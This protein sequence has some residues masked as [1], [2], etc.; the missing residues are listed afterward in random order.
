MMIVLWLVL[1]VLFVCFLLIVFRGAPYVPTHKR[2]VEALFGLY[3]FKPGEVLVDLGSGDGRVLV[4]AAKRG[5]RAVGYELN[6]FLVF[7]SRWRL[8]REENVS[9]KLQDF[10][11]A[12]LPDDTAVV[13]VFLA[14]PFMKKLDRKLTAEAQRLGH[15]IILVSYGMKIIGKTQEREQGGLLNYR[16]YAD[17][18]A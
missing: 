8:G 14:D 11:S 12:K 18:K 3:D 13:F 5:V 15:D 7:Y 1:A 4:E 9:V 6:P 2:D 16:Y 10:W 17:N